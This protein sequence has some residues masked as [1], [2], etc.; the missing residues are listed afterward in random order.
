MTFD[1]KKVL[2]FGVQYLYLIYTSVMAFDRLFLAEK[3]VKGDAFNSL[4]EVQEFALTL[5]DQNGIPPLR[6]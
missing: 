6:D 2:F 5:K 4:E 1:Y 3:L